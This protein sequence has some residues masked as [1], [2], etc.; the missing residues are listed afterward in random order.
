VTT[1][2]ATLG[3]EAFAKAREAGQALSLEETI[4]EALALADTLTRV[5]T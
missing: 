2:Q 4:A 1:V 3:E 5:K